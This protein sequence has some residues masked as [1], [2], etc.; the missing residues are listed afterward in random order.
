MTT[1]VYKNKTYKVDSTGYLEDFR[2]WDEDY[3]VG[4]APEVEIKDGLTEE[5]WKVIH[6]I[7]N[8]FLEHGKCP[9]IYQTCRA[10][11]LRLRELQKL[12]PTGYQRGACKLAG[13]TYR[14]GYLYTWLPAAEEELRPVVSDKVYRVDVRGFLL[15]P[16][17]WD[18]Q[19][20]IHKAYELKMPD[21][22][23]DNHWKVI[24]F[25]RDSYMKTKVVP[26]VYET[27]KANN[28]E[29]EDLERLFPDGYH[30]GAVKIA[31]LRVR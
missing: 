1:F 13:I 7:R 21:T 5:H 10:N 20:A 30:R 27:C 18:T 31:G 28:F 19:F 24:N 14:E 25:L 16:E 8:T 17:E 6:Y 4:M 3:A 26:T 12:F 2:E 9:L 29:L 11:N 23:T 15:D 22:L